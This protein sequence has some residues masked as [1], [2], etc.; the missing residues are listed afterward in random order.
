M[1]SKIKQFFTLIELLVVIAIIGILAAMLLPVLA[2]SRD[3][4]RTIKCIGNLKQLGSLANMYLNSYDESFPLAHD[5]NS[6]WDHDGEGGPGILYDG[7]AYSEIQQCPSFNGDSYETDDAPFTGYNYNVTYVGHGTGE[8]IVAPARLSQMRQPSNCVLFGDGELVLG[9]VHYT[10]KYMRAPYGSGRFGVIP[11]DSAMVR[12]GV[13][14]YRH[15]GKTNICWADAHAETWKTINTS[16]YN[17]GGLLASGIGFICWDDELY[18][19]D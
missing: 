18:D 17:P 2:S 5:G 8:A 19:L 16:H 1:F 3:R 9:G 13:Q 15:N 7:T 6:E 10:N 11:S 14:G 4:G 12:A